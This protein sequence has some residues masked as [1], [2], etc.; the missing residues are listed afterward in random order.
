LITTALVSG[1]KIAVDMRRADAF[2]A[3]NAAWF[4]SPCYFDS[5]AENAYP[6]GTAASGGPISTFTAGEMVLG[7][8]GGYNV[9]QDVAL[10]ISTPGAGFTN[11]V[12]HSVT[13][14]APP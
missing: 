3:V 5:A 9:S 2:V 10:L 14:V 7:V 8:F 1:D 13:S 6:A 11:Q 4:T 12:G